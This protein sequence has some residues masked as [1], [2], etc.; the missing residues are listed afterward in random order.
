MPFDYFGV[1]V[2][3][4]GNYALV[5]ASGGHGGRIG[6]TPGA[7]FLYNKGSGQLLHKFFAPDG[8]YQFGSSVAVS[9]SYVLVGAPTFDGAGAYLYNTTGQLLHAFQNPGRIP[10]E[11]FGTSVALS[12]NRVLIGASGAAYLYDASGRLLH[13][14]AAPAG[15]DPDYSFGYQAALSGRQVLIGAAEAY[16]RTGAAFL[17]DASGRL[18]E[19]IRKPDGN[20]GDHFAA[21]LA[22]SGSNMLIGASGENEGVAYLYSTAGQLLQTL[23]YPGTV[24]RASFGSSLAISGINVLVASHTGVTYLYNTFGNLLDTLIGTSVAISGATA[25]FGD[26]AGKLAYAFQ[27]PP[28]L[29]SAATGNNQHTVV[30]TAFG[31]PLEAQITD[32]S[33]NPLEGYPVVFTVRSGVHGAAG[34]FGGSTTISAMSDAQ[35]LAVAPAVLANT[36]AGSFSVAIS[37][38][39]V[40]R[41]VIL[42]LTNTAG[43][44]SALKVLAG[45]HQSATT[46]SSF[47]SALEV[48][49]VDVFGNSVSGVSVTFTVLNNPANGAGGA[50][51]GGKATAVVIANAHGVAKAPT[52]TA[53]GKAGTFKVNATAD[54]LLQAAVFH[55]RTEVRVVV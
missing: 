26:Y 34:T 2:A 45:N 35:G 18:L 47:T 8:S 20:T 39:G 42:T 46:E 16:A 9:G 49:V 28:P 44:L 37:A 17:F 40:R 22:L 6:G 54:G 13:T 52:L 51:A 50:F 33:G 12:G 53:N 41:P 14:F 21:S 3:I 31:N 4:S 11:F 10:Q 43:A 25:I 32:S 36:I 15:A 23:E 1:S 27:I 30:D 48:Q 19:T 29:L 24:P 55:L 7:A 38:A 5:G